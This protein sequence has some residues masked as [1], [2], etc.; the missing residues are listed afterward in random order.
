MTLLRLAFRNLLRHPWR[1]LATILGVGLGI[2]AVLATLSV[3]D[4]VHA[5]VASALEAATG[6]ADLLVTPGAAGRA[7]F[8]IDEVLPIVTNTPGVARA[9]AVLNTRAEPLRDIQIERDSLIPG[10]DSGFQL[11]GRQTEYPDELPAELTVGRYPV[12]G[13]GGVAI[14]AGF[15]KSRQIALGDEV[16]FATQFGE[17]PFIVT[18]LLDDSL[19]LGSTNGGRVG[20]TALEDLQAALRL[21]GRASFLE[22]SLDG[23]RPLHEVQRD[24]EARLGEGYT[25][26][27][28]ALSGNLATGIVDTL[29]AGL[30][31]LAA[32]LIV[33]GG[34]MAYNTFAAATVERTREYALLRTICFTRAQIRRLAM[35]EALLVSAFGVA[36]GLGLGWLLAYGMTYLN[37]A[38]LGFELRTVVVPV[39]NVA[40]AALVGVGISLLA[41][42]LPAR[43]AAR[44]PP[45]AA[46]RRTREAAVGATS[47][48]GWAALAAG[49]GAALAP[50][51]N[52]WAIAGSALAMGLLFTGV[53]LT[54]P[55][56]LRPTVSLLT[57]LLV[58]LFGNPG[59]LGAGFA[60]RSGTRNG[61]AVGAVVVGIS[62][63]I[64]VGA[65]VEGINRDIASWVETTIAG[66]LFVTTPVGFPADFEQQ[67]L[68]RAPEIAAASGVGLRVVRFEPEG[69]RQGRSVVLILVEPE[70]FDPAQ[71]FGRFQFI[72]GQGDALSGYEALRRGEV[73]AANTIL[74]RFGVARGDTVSL[75]TSEGFRE[76]RVGGVVVDFT[77]GGEAFVISLNELPRFGGGVPDLYVMLTRPDA[78]AEAAREALLRAFP[79]LYLDVTLNEAYQE[80]ILQLTRQ[81]FATTHALL[82]LAIFIAALGVANTLGMNLATRAREIAVLRALGL[83]RQG[84]RRLVSAE[85]LVV[86]LLGAVLGVLCGLLLSHVV[87]AGANALTGYR[88]TPAY[89]WPLIGLALASSPLV[90]LLA[91][92]FPARRA[93]SL[94]PKRALGAAES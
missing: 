74:D 51:P 17:Q 23:S 13:E 60:R 52:A 14:A 4:N 11:S 54:A 56:L 3:G 29:Q 89:P 38:T 70:R 80:R 26:T 75:R 1:A 76:F 7:V 81:T 28:P 22:V 31:V 12:A 84:V 24:L 82:V 58:R 86:A 77:G 91:S 64:G 93:A 85:G 94:P 63:T 46:M 71:G 50:W 25:A 21:A 72:A 37:A 49:V 15:A 10:I 43:E 59:Q 34:F 57:P 42:L 55:A 79:E 66:D 83:T 67:V 20:L 48:W 35:T 47:P 40:L 32:A 41:G 53:T 45:L 78:P 36:A 92:L 69:Q 9:R 6:Q 19:G 44:T 8:A 33:L 61:V 30:Q 18:G 73:L 2:A 90:G 5:N 27:L 62:L 39:G 87:T 16:R 68:E 88:V 65:M